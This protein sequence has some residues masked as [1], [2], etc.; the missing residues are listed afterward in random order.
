MPGSGSK[1]EKKDIQAVGLRVL[2]VG[3]KTKI[4]GLEF[5]L[6]LKYI[7]SSF[8]LIWLIQAAD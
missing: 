1:W 4:L 2:A 6:L 3:F 7:Y 5:I 8:N